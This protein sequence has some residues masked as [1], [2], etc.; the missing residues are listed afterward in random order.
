M[1]GQEGKKEV[2]GKRL[3]SL[4]IRTI[5]RAAAEAESSKALYAD[6]NEGQLESQQSINHL[7]HEIFTSW[8]LSLS[9]LS[10]PS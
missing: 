5:I 1:G 3:I 2:Q 10:L 7:H 6:C 8:N 9:L 4:R